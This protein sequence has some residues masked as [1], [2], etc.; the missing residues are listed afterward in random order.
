M[1]DRECEIAS[2]SRSR[3][4]RPPGRLPP[5]GCLLRLAQASEARVA[6]GKAECAL[7]LQVAG[8]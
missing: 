2:P 7:A 5:A 4:P 3:A 8:H 1:A 6:A